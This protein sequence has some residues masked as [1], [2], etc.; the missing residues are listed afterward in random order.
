M[1][2]DLINLRRERKRRARDAA[3]ETAE[4]NRTA[5]GLSKAQREAL[6]RERQTADRRL[7]GHALPSAPGGPGETDPRRT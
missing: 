5:F 2:G 7:D 4:A 6:R 1:S 3:A